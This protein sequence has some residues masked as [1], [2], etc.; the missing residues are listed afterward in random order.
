[1]NDDKTYGYVITNERE[2]IILF[3]LLYLI[4]KTNILIIK[5]IYFITFGYHLYKLYNN[6][7]INKKIHKNN[8]KYIYN[9]LLLISLLI[10]INYNKYLLFGILFIL[11]GL[12]FRINSNNKYKYNE[13]LYSNNKII[14]IVSLLLLILYPNYKYNFIF[15]IEIIDHSII[16]YERYW[17][18]N[19]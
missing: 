13:I 12:L 18:K 15:I 7:K 1:M 3:L 9:I 11:T 19:E 4:S 6:Y 8:E 14:I 10:G 5:I 17:I 16:E 2:Y